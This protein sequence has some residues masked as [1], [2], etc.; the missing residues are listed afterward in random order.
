LVCNL[1]L[2]PF[3]RFSFDELEL[4]SDCFSVSPCGAELGVLEIFLGLL[5]GVLKEEEAKNLRQ[6]F[7]TSVETEEEAS[8]PLLLL[9]IRLRSCKG[10]RG[11]RLLFELD[12]AVVIGVGGGGGGK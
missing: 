4:D 9:E 12:F 2:L 5:T 10:L 1:T 8:L 6:P 11:F 7:G 3:G